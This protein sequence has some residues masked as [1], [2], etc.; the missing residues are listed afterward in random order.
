M[1]TFYGNDAGYVDGDVDVFNPTD[2]DMDEWLDAFVAAGMKYATICARTEDG[3]CLW[4]TTFADAGHDPYGI[5]STEWYAA[6][7]NY[8]IL[9]HYLDGLRARGMKTVLYFPVRDLTHEARSGTDE[10]SGTAAYIAM[11]KLE[12]TE[13]LTNYGVIDAIF[14][15]DW[16]WHIAYANIP[17]Y[18][19]YNHIKGIQPNCLILNNEKIHPAI[20]SDIEVYEPW[21][22]IHVPEGNLRISE[23]VETIRLDNVWSYNEA[24]DQTATALMTKAQINAAVAQANSRNSNYIIGISPDKT[25]HLTAAQKSILESLQV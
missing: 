20:C 24:L 16:N 23:E 8:D 17:Y 15:D 19:L 22:D 6:N 7:G 13:L 9:D 21:N 4:P 25:G 11:L 2:L 3:F 5:G 14:L 1:S 18:T 12:L 10:V